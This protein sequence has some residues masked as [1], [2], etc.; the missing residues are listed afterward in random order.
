MC[1]RPFF[2]ESLYSYRTIRFF[3]PSRKSIVLLVLSISLCS[4]S[5]WISGFF[6]SLSRWYL[7]CCHCCR[8]VVNR[9]QITCIKLKP[10]SD[11]LSSSSIL[12]V[13]L[14]SLLY[15]KYCRSGWLCHSSYLPFILFSLI[16]TPKI[17]AR[18]F[19][20]WLADFAEF[21]WNG[22]IINYNIVNKYSK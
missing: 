11:R 4:V 1:A 13:L 2:L 19:Y 7:V 18:I 12:H 5:F 14:L 10:S 16:P 20:H 17:I 9:P 22:S 3:F 6:F 15:F 21:H 8:I